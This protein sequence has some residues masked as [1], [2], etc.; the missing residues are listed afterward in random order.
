MAR[1]RASAEALT[2]ELAAR[3][4]EAR[5]PF[6]E[7]LRALEAKHWAALARVAQLTERNEQLAVTLL[8]HETAVTREARRPIV[9]RVSPGLRA[10]LRWGSRTMLVVLYVSGALVARKFHHLF[11]LQL[12]MLA[13]LPVTVLLALLVGGLRGD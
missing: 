13:A 2:A 10:A 6:D 7:A 4:A 8:A 12:A 5:A 1:A 11:G 9:H 3:E